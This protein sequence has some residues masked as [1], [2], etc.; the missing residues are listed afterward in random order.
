MVYKKRCYNSDHDNIVRQQ[1]SMK[2]ECLPSLL[3]R[4]ECSP[5]GRLHSHEHT[6]IPCE[7]NL[8]KICTLNDSYCIKLIYSYKR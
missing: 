4:N 1:S 3:V 5:S 2:H 6:I 8:S 7:K